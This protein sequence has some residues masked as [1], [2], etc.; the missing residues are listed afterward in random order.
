MNRAA[1]SEAL[2]SRQPAMIRGWLAMMPTVEPSIRA[3]QVMMFRA[4]IR[5][6][7]TY[8]PLSTML[9]MTLYMS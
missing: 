5:W 3:R 1:L 2:I 8:S 4:Y 7:S 9:R 6:G